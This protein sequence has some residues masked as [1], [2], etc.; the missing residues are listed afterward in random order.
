MARPIRAVLLDRDGVIVVNRPTNIKRPEDLEL[1]AGAAGALR[2]LSEAG[3]R[4]AICTNQPEVGRGALSA[5]DLREVHGA[6]CARLRAE[7]AAIEFVLSCDRL[8]KCPRLKPA[9]GMLVEAMAR[10]GTAPHATAYI[11]DQL[12]D[13][14][15]AFR[16]GC[17]RVLVTTGLGR[18]T[19]LE[20]WPA[21]VKPV[22]VCK[23]LPAAAEMLSRP[24]QR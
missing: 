12:D 19:L 20:S 4:L 5:Q 6:L 1:I 2:N 17:R 7:G 23:D 3:V 11:G 14:K 18:K 16:A 13:L 10:L 24:P 8:R 9:G 22:L 15:A 21:Y